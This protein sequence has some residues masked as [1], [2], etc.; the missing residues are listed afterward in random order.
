MGATLSKMWASFRS[1]FA[2]G[3]P[4]AGKNGNQQLH[5]QNTNAAVKDVESGTNTPLARSTDPTI[6]PEIQKF[7]I[8]EVCK[9]RML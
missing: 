1:A 9:M 4:P 2:G 8:T 6:M 5:S 3:A 7:E